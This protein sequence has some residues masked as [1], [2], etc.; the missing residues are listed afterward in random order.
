[1]MR[2]IHL[3]WNLH[4]VSTR[5]GG[6]EFNF[7]WTAIDGPQQILCAGR[8]AICQSVESKKIQ[9][10]TPPLSF[11][12]FSTCNCKQNRHRAEMLARILNTRCYGAVASPVLRNVDASG[13][14]VSELPKI[15]TDTRSGG[16]GVRSELLEL[17]DLCVRTVEDLW[18]GLSLTPAALILVSFGG[19]SVT[20]DVN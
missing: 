14:K 4:F 19:A 11:T 2:G 7:C 1:M 3:A 8:T 16:F 18:T 9:L 17:C 10:V 5:D 12:R 6:T 15:E 13:Q 20:P